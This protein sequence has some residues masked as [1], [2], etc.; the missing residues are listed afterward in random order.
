MFFLVHLQSIPKMILKLLFIKQPQMSRHSIVEHCWPF[1]AHVC[2]VK[3]MNADIGLAKYLESERVVHG[4]CIM[5]PWLRHN[6]VVTSPLCGCFWWNRSTKGLWCK[7]FDAFFV[8][9]LDKILNK[10]S[11]RWNKTL[12]LTSN[13]NG[14]MQDYNISS[15]LAMEILQSCTKPLVWRH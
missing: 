2:V 11:G 14:L 15:A 12:I 13:I 7:M 3:I 1:H 4:Q 9:S 6:S 10:P 5:T 8:V